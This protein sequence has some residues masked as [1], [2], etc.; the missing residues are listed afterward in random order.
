MK[1]K[2]NDYIINTK[3]YDFLINMV[4]ISVNV[5]ITMTRLANKKD[6]T[7]FIKIGNAS[8]TPKMIWDDHLKNPRRVHPPQPR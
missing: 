7:M 3:G 6:N 2:G 5:E 4:H 1:K 8:L